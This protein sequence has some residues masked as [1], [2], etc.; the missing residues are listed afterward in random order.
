MFTG[1]MVGKT[2]PMCF[3]L[4]WG[5]QHPGDILNSFLQ[6]SDVFLLRVLSGHP[7][8]RTHDPWGAIQRFL[9]VAN[10]V[11][12]QSS[13]CETPH[14]GRHERKK[15]LCSTGDSLLAGAVVGAAAQ[16]H[17]DHTAGERHEQRVVIPIQLEA[18]H[19]PVLPLHVASRNRRKKKQTP[20]VKI[21][22][23]RF[24]FIFKSAPQTNG[25]V[26][27]LYR[28]PAVNRS[29]CR[30]AS[31]GVQSENKGRHGGKKKKHPLELY[32]VMQSVT[33]DQSVGGQGRSRHNTGSRRGRKI[34]SERTKTVRSRR[35]KLEEKH[36][37]KHRNEMCG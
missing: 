37:A 27:K 21:R 20:T 31:Q 23:F 10:Q 30:S 15:K 13:N 17:A 25:T 24:H 9:A 28:K 34:P 5:L 3:G 1:H 6:E 11:I 29:A 35:E 12:G 4:P 16:R 36:G 32:R 26:W 19:P 14:W 33:I 8:Q 2:P 18:Q 22:R 7:P